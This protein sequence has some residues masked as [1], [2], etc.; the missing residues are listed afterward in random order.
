[1][2]TI[3]D[4]DID[5]V[6]QDLLTDAIKAHIVADAQGLVADAQG[7]LAD[8]NGVLADA[9]GVAVSPKPHSATLERA[10]ATPLSS[11]SNPYAALG[12]HEN[13]SGANPQS[14]GQVLAGMDNASEP[15]LDPEFSEQLEKVG[16]ECLG[17]IAADTLASRKAK[18]LAL[19]GAGAEARAQLEMIA[20]TRAIERVRIFARQ[21]IA[22]AELAKQFSARTGIRTEVV[23]SPEEALHNADMVILATSS[24][25]PVIEASWVAPGTFITSLGPKSKS[26]HEL[27]VN[28]ARRAKIIASDS[29]RQ[30]LADSDHFLAGETAIRR[31]THLG[32][33][34]GKFDPDRDRG[35]TLFLSSGSPETEVVT[36][37]VAVSYLDS[38]RPMRAHSS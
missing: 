14:G 1:M 5:R 13:L 28:I 12:T 18:T 7:V 20:P 38:D 31:I 34:V 4:T 27:P 30:V 21:P 25:E 29:P 6:P 26:R 36:L 9:N 16:A 33:L 10:A 2:R 37:K 19:I 35:I 23:G 24:G 17:C 22:A 3:T 11:G 15:M 32:S 8:A